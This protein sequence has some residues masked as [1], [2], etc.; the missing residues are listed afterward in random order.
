MYV[1]VLLSIGCN[2]EAIGLVTLLYNE[3]YQKLKNPVGVAEYIH[4]L[5]G[6][7]F[8]CIGCRRYNSLLEMRKRGFV[9]L[10]GD[11]DRLEYPTD[12]YFFIQELKEC[13]K[14]Y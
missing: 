14:N 6:L 8:N 3:I 2:G 5:R 1:F 10:A 11:Y 7:F 4:T 12:S 13:N 9:N